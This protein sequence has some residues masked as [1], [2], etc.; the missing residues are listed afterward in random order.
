MAR[1]VVGITLEVPTTS[2]IAALKRFEDTLDALITCWVGVRYVAGRAVALGD[3]TAAIWLSRVSDRKIAARVLRAAP[4]AAREGRTLR[5]PREPVESAAI[6][7]ESKT[8]TRPISRVCHKC[9][10]E[11][12]A[13]DCS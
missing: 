4:N 11:L 3:D 12:G 6:H 13:N 1:E 10:A 2:E 5:A 8:R 9:A 7:R